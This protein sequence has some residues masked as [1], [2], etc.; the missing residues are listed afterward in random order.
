M[1]IQNKTMILIALSVIGYAIQMFFKTKGIDGYSVFMQIFTIN[2]DGE[3]ISI[4]TS[5]FMHGNIIHIGMNMLMLFLLSR[6]YSERDSFIKIYF[7]SGLA[8]S[9]FS[10]VYVN[11]I[12]SEP[13]YVLG[14]SGAIFGIFSYIFFKTNRRKEFYLNFLIFNIGMIVI[15][16]NIAWYAHLGGAIAGILYYYFE[17]DIMPKIRRKKLR[18]V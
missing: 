6:M 14:A 2:Q 7:I 11:Y 8:S 3:L 9:V 17:N 15:G 5:M 4:F 13:A 1:T 12:S 16:M 18:R 10:L